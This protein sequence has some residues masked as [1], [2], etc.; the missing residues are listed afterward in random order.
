M[1]LFKRLVPVVFAMLAATGPARALDIDVT[2][3]K[4]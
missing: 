4:L 1:I 3:F 2:T